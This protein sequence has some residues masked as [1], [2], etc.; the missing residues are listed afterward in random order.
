M[1]HSEMILAVAG[2]GQKDILDRT[3]KLASGDWSSFPP[4][5][6][7]AYAFA[8]KQSREPW[9][10]TGDD[11]AG[12]VRHFGKERAL[13]VIWW[14]C[15]CHFMTR[16]ADAFQLSLE[17][18]NVFEGMFPPKEKQKVKPMEKPKRP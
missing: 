16:F 6:R 8:D 13:D 14:S 10:V 9:S 1:G 5:E 2:L 18:D 7:A 15:R 12:L 4:A 3:S 17:R 11:V